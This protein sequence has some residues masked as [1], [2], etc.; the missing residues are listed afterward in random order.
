MG[1]GRWEMGDKLTHLIAAEI[2]WQSA[3]EGDLK[4]P[5]SHLPSPISLHLPCPPEL[6]E[7]GSSWHVDR[8]PTRA[9]RRYG[10]GV[11]GLRRLRHRRHSPRGILVLS[12]ILGD[13]SHGKLHGKKNSPHLPNRLQVGRSRP[14]DAVELCSRACSDVIRTDAHARARH[15]HGVPRPA[16]RDVDRG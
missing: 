11:A 3:L 2:Q 15:R 16:G 1:D 6:R 5:I 12:G 8:L 7:P 4:S 9:I 10:S 13:G 14:R